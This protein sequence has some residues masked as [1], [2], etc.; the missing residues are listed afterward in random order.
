MGPEEPESVP[1]EE[2]RPNFYDFDFLGQL[3][4]GQC[5]QIEGKTYCPHD[6]VHVREVDQVQLAKHHC[7]VFDDI[8]AC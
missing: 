5:I 1:V 4:V 7:S 2:V 6:P 8:I 3:F